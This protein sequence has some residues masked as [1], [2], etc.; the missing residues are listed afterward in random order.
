MSTSTES[1]PASLN[2]AFVE[3]MYES[4]LRDHSSVSEDWVH[5]FESMNGDA[6]A[7]IP[8]KL[9]PSF[10]STSIFNP[11]G[12]N[13]QNGKSALQQKLDRNSVMQHKVDLLIRNY[14]VRGH[15]MSCMDTMGAPAFDLPELE[16]AY[17]GFT[18]EDL[19]LHFATPSLK[20]ADS[21]T[22]RE[23]IARYQNTYCRSIGV[24]FMH[25]DDL[26]VRDW[27]QD[28]MEIAENRFSLSRDEQVRILKR[29]TDAISFEEFIQKKYQGAKSFSLEGAESLIPLLDQAI[30]KAGEHGVDEIVI[31]MAHR[32]RLN[33]LANIMGKD[34]AQIFREYEDKNPD[35]YKGRGD[36][37]YHQGFH[38]DW[39]T[40][41]GQKVHLALCFNP[42][43]LEYVNTVAMGRMRSWMD[44][45]G[46]EKH[47]KGMVVLIHG[48]AAFAG[49]GIV[50][51]TLNMSCLKAYT[52]GGT[53]HIIVNNQIGFTTNPGDSRSSTYC[54]DV[55]KMLQSPIFHVD[56]EDPEAVAQV[57]NVAMEF[58]RTFK[59]DVVID[60]YCYRKHGHNEGDEPMFTQPLMYKE[61][62][63]RQSVKDNYMNRLLKMGELTKEDAD[64]IAELRRGK[65]EAALTDARTRPQVRPPS[66]LRG[67]W[68]NYQGGPD[69]H[70][71]DVDTGV[72]HDRLVSLI[73]SLTNVPEGFNLNAK[74]NRILGVRRKMATGEAPIDWAMGE[75]LAMATLATEGARVRLTG[76]DSQRGTFSHR[77]SV[78]H[79][80]E[81]A[82]TYMPLQHL[83]A[84]QA[85]VEIHNSPLCES[86]VLAFEYGYSFAYP[87]GLVMWEAQF[88]DFSNVAQPI[89]DQFIS[90]AEDKWYRLSGLTILLPHGF[91]G[92][93]PEHSSS[94]FERFLGLAAEDNFQVCV[95]TTPAQ[96][97]HL[98]RR[99]VRR[100]WRKPLIII[101]PKSLLRK[102]ECTS[103]LE[104]LIHG[105]FRRLLRDKDSDPKKVERILMCTGKIFYEL[106]EA[107]KK[108]GRDDIAI[109]RVEQLYPLQPDDVHE[110]LDAYE[111]ETPVL[112]VQEEPEN[113]GAWR[114]MKGKFGE[115]IL[116][117]F[118]FTVASRPASASPATG[119]AHSHRLEQENLIQLAL[120]NEGTSWY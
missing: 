106:D 81:T 28:T 83:S 32:G 47:E 46:D 75:T 73:E 31:G 12:G 77:H 66:L 40:T 116:G 57:V 91:E 85:E 49:Q 48:D 65:L 25:I 78:L 62:R 30:D 2:V 94:R 61:I 54:T 87:D 68:S 120:G 50:Q 22:L 101:T 53:L 103:T 16:P 90:S 63:K 109:I 35:S 64:D 39:Q 9:N 4:Y 95:P 107:R 112:W 7:G 100:P 70:V 56:G 92:M 98:L 84:N 113:M 79:D 89:F 55:A 20:D 60:M 88:G 3:D 115:R 99:Q 19:D 14:R 58:R 44:R 74:V 26:Q 104:D 27:L 69:I 93:G 76:Q 5:Y 6:T 33:V 15:L 45:T 118:P 102:P 8:P 36:V 11:P 37:K 1:N 59:R 82:E 52:T 42:S 72:E 24:Q 117:Q 23:I 80:Q 105:R 119:S 71:P 96:M 111:P 86:G 38:N 110:V 41:C 17:H 21:M 114:R 43:H 29:L 13:A 10:K 51:E 67:I 97:F 34:P 108:E 18:D